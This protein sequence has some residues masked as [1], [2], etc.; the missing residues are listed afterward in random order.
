MACTWIPLVLFVCERHGPLSHPVVQSSIDISQSNMANGNKLVRVMWLRHATLLAYF[1]T[2]LAG[3]QQ[4]VA[5]S[6]PGR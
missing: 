3:Y 6:L 2:L 4:I 5:G 1:W